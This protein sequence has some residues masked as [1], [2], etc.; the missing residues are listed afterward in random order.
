MV[1]KNPGHSG[2]VAFPNYLCKWFCGTLWVLGWTSI[3]HQ[4][5]LPGRPKTNCFIRVKLRPAVAVKM[6]EKCSGIGVRLIFCIWFVR[7]Q[8]TTGDVHIKNDSAGTHRCRRSAAVHRGR[9]N[10]AAQNRMSRPVQFVGTG[11]RGRHNAVCHCWVT[12]P[13]HS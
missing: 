10:V 2:R 9:R 7:G 6:H 4:S 13:L 11:T 5:Y 8:W 3:S 12:K 1:A